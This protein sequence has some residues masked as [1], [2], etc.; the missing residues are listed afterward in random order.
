MQSENA[1]IHQNLFSGGLNKDLNRSFVESAEYFDAHNLTLVES[2]KF[3]ALENIKG[4]TNLQTIVNDSTTIVLKVFE[5]NY[6]IGATEGV[7]CLTIFTAKPNDYFKILCYDINNDVL[8]ELYRE[9]VSSDYFTDD[10]LIDV[11]LYPENGIDLLYF[12]DFYTGH[13]IRKL[14]CEIPVSYSPWFVT[15]AEI[16][17]ARSGALGKVELSN[18]IDGGSLFCGSYLFAYQLFVPGTNKSTRFSL[19]SHPIQIFDDS[20]VYPISQVGI[21][22]TKKILLN[23]FPSENELAAYTHFRLAVIENIYPESDTRTTALLTDTFL[24]NDY[25]SG[26]YIKN[27]EYSSNLNASATP[28]PIEEIVVDL[29]AIDTVKTITVRDN[30]LLAG[31]IKYKDLSFD[32]GTP[33]ITGGSILKETFDFYEDGNY[34]KATRNVGYFRDEVYRFAISY[35]DGNGNFSPPS[36]LNMSPVI[37]NAFSGLIASPENSIAITNYD[38]DNGLTGWSQVDPGT[39]ETG[40]SAVTIPPN[41]FGPGGTLAQTSTV[42]T[43]ADDYTDIIYQPMTIGAG[44]YSLQTRISLFLQSLFDSLSTSS[45]QIVYLDNANTILGT[46]TLPLSAAPVLSDISTIAVL[47]QEITVPSGTTRIGF[48]GKATTVSDGGYHLVIDFV[49]I[50][51]IHKDMKFPARHDV[52]GG[53]RFSVLNSDNKPINLGLSLTG[54]SNHP[55]WA[56]GFVILRAKRKEDILWESPIIPM[57]EHYGI[58]AVKDYP[59]RAYETEAQTEVLYPNAQ[60]QG[61]N[62]TLFPNNYFF[63][64]SREFIKNNISTGSGLHMITQGEVKPAYESTYGYGLVFPPQTMY[65]NSSQYSF[66]SAHKLKA[67]D[68]ALV[69]LN[70]KTY[71]TETEI[72]LG[73]GLGNFMD[74]S[75]SGTIYAHRDEMYYIDANQTGK[76]SLGT[77]TMKDY[78]AFD[79]LSTGFSL[80]GVDVMRKENLETEGITW[81][82]DGYNIQRGAVVQLFDGTGNVPVIINSNAAGGDTLTF[83]GGTAKPFR[84]DNRFQT[85]TS[86]ILIGN[87]N[88]VQIMNCIA[89]LPDNRYGTPNSFNEYILTGAHVVFSNSELLT[90]QSGGSLPKSV[91][92]WGGDCVVTRHTYKIADT[93]YNVVNGNKFLIAN[94]GEQSSLIGRNWDRAFKIASLGG[95]NNDPNVSLLLPVKNAAMYIDIFLQSKYNGFLNNT[96]GILTNSTAS[97]VKRQ[98]V[99]SASRTPIT[100]DLNPNHVKE[101]DYKIFVPVDT[102]FPNVTATKARIIYSDQKVY[103]GGVEGFDV[104]R[105]L[106]FYDLGENFGGITKIDTIGNDT[107]A[108]QEKAVTY[109]A[110][111]ERILEQTDANELAVRTGDVIGNTI[112]IDTNKGCQHMHSV[113]NTGEVLYFLDNFNKAAYVL[114]ARTLKNISDIGLQSEFRNLF[115]TVKPENTIETIYDPVR[116]EWWLSDVDANFCYVFN[117]GLNKWVSNYDFP[118]GVLGGTYTNQ[119]LYLLGRDDSG[120]SVHSMYT[121]TDSRLFGEYVVPSVQFIINPEYQFGK[122]FDNLLVVASDRLNN[123]DLLVEREVSLGDQAANGLSIDVPSRGLGNYKVKILRDINGA[124]LKGSSMKALVRWKSTP[125]IEPVTLTSVLTQYRPILKQF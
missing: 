74:T 71:N 84:S 4:T 92:V 34:E 98:Q 78:R 80:N 100:Y 19:L 120:L 66:S 102:L 35:F 104:F 117:A 125:S 81:G 24:I 112:I 57:M 10:R 1:K 46:E 28:V 31:N 36:P 63:E 18:V 42:M 99:E 93:Y 5:C 6:K 107:Y 114:S 55:T 88:T 45:F 83:A 60:P 110:V 38:F 22:T 39:G 101:N 123:V 61:P 40:W 23:I 13:G 37:G 119:N 91:N 25:L 82:I 77:Y 79:N 108:L 20:G 115:S 32:N 43:N 54:I 121:N 64:K 17:L 73:N 14:R 12:T 86:N 59:T 7:K 52:V 75:V 106:N 51:T 118:D 49:K 116:R 97:S 44:V 3:L 26:G 30:R 48:R 53:E 87:S 33:T 11:V 8:Y 2:N 15:T 21:S 111:G 27:V 69:D 9:A 103:Q 76:S 41:I 124:R 50:N 68:A 122:Q 29:A 85:L 90:V 47:Q 65:T 113:S 70:G 95:S 67:V 105:A 109:I 16:S 96:N 56:K 58:G 89:G 94:G 62:T 72:S